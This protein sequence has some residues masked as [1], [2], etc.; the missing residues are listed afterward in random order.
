MSTPAYNSTGRAMVTAGMFATNA[1][2]NALLA[3]NGE[4]L[5][6]Q[7]RDLERRN[8]WARNSVDAYVGNVVGTGAMPIPRHRNK[9]TRIRLV[10]EF[11]RWSIQSDAD[12]RTDFYGQQSLVVR[13]GFVAGE[14]IARLRPRRAGDGLRVPLQVQLLEPDHL[15]LTKNEL[16]QGGNQI[17]SGIE[18][19]RIGRRVAYHL[20]REHP[21]EMQR[22]FSAGETIRVPAEQI[23]HVFKQRRP[24]QQR[25]ETEFAACMLPLYELEKY[26]RAE[27]VRKAVTSM[28][29]IF[30]RDID[31]GAE[32]LFGANANGG[33]AG[34]DDRPIQ[35]VEP[36]S[37]VR[38]P[39]GK[40]IEYSD[41]KDVGGMYPEFIRVQLRKIA[42]GCGL[43]YEML[44][45]DLTGVNY[46]SIRAGLLEFR[47]RAEAFQH[48]V[49]IHQFCRPVWEAW[50]DAAA[51]SGV[52]DPADYL[53]NR[54]E[55]LDVEWQ[56]PAWD[57]VDPLKDIQ[58]EVLAIDNL[59][60]ARQQTI[61]QSGYDPEEVDAMIADD[62][63]SEESLGL[64]RRTKQGQAFQDPN[65]NGERDAA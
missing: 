60:K 35:P 11:R 1:S 31:G 27:L 19:D 42:A 2:I 18:Y 52:I 10:R 50:C 62:Q 54:D 44:S 7:A 39:S 48:Q 23:L 6:R 5:R 57:W 14:T 17:I 20:Y 26:D 32:P 33:E 41:P 37:Y 24:G 4:S 61:K 30:E 58:A 43:T 8:C 47:R 49:L 53:T 28:F 59:L 65:Q 22:F 9:A 29:A 56:P 13:S 46:S 51:L 25:G 36:G 16:A 34:E 55:Y 21:G 63:E 12:N 40:T 45:G 64:V 15:P 3:A 38:L